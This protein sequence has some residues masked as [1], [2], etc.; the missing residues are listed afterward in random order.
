MHRYEEVHFKKISEIYIKYPKLRKFHFIFKVKNYLLMNSSV[1]VSTLVLLG[2]W[3]INPNR[4]IDA[5]GQI[6]YLKIGFDVAMYILFAFLLF[7]VF[8]TTRYILSLFN[9]YILK[10]G[11]GSLIGIDRVDEDE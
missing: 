7:S 9:V 10:K 1:I 2:L 8:L 5:I 11:R 3:L 4:V 6:I